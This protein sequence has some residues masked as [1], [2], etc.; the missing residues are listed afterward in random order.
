[1]I[2]FLPAGFLER[3]YPT[4][5]SI[6]T[7]PSAPIETRGT[8]SCTWR[9]WQPV[10]LLWL[11]N[12]GGLVDM[13][14]GEDVGLLVDGGPREFAEAVATLLRDNT[15]R[16]AMGRNGYELVKQKYSRA[17]MGSRYLD[18]YRRLLA[19]SRPL[20]EAGKNVRQGEGE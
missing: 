20:S 12:E 18:Y 16:F 10:L 4:F 1:M 14:R 6:L 17:A 13:L 11:I 15:R 3:G 2:S 7:S 9:V 8:G 19:D 5:F